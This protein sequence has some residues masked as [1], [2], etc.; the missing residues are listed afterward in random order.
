MQSLLKPTFS[1]EVLTNIQNGAASSISMLCNTFVCILQAFE[2]EAKKKSDMEQQIETMKRELSTATNA[3]KKTARSIEST[4]DVVNTKLKQQCI[5]TDAK[6]SDMRVELTESIQGITDKSELTQKQINQKLEMTESRVGRTVSNIETI[7]ERIGESLESMQTE[8]E[9][10]K[11][12]ILTTAKD[13]STSMATLQREVAQ[14][15]DS[16]KSSIDSVNDKFQLLR[17]EVDKIVSTKADVADLK[18]KADLETLDEFKLFVKEQRSQDCENC[19][20]KCEEIRAKHDKDTDALRGEA[21]QIRERN[22]ESI[23]NLQ[24]VHQA[25][26]E[27]VSSRIQGVQSE[28]EQLRDKEPD[29]DADPDVMTVIAE[30]K[31]NMQK[32]ADA[33][34]RSGGMTGDPSCTTLSG[35]C[36]SCGQPFK[37]KL[38]FS[39]ST[40]AGGGFNPHPPG[41]ARLPSSL[42]SSREY[43]TE[44]IAHDGQKDGKIKVAVSKRQRQLRR[45]KSFSHVR[46]RPSTSHV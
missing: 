11:T 17:Y 20:A 18:W 26:L 41:S 40:T 37:P 6:L 24:Q 42:S 33:M 16:I 1:D 34:P 13:V 19:Q 25:S 36:F 23:E 44:I 5:D 4:V 28:M 32:L 10:L 35:N 30:M 7:T 27:G 8:H 46:Q 31:D 39:T 15:R 14:S 22:Q 12:E 38:K 3:M 2:S 43:Y 29:E 21:E 45:S 9:K